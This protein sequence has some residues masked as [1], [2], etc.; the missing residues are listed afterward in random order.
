MTIEIEIYFDDLNPEAQKEFL[1]KLGTTPEEENWDI[2]PIA[3]FEREEDDQTNVNA[4]ILK[5]ANPQVIPWL[6]KQQPNGS[7]NKKDHNFEVI[8]LAIT[9]RVRAQIVVIRRT[10]NH[11]KQM[12]IY[13]T[14]GF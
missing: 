6:M 10:C 9:D 12:Q 13:T 11:E 8:R 4:F 1:E 14:T 5:M 2:C 3:I 7:L